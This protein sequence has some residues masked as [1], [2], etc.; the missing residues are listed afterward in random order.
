MNKVE[1][2]KFGEEEYE[3]SWIEGGD[4]A[5]ELVSQVSGYV[6]NNKGEILIVKNKNWTIPGGH[7]EEGEDY[8]ETLRREI[9]EESNVKI[10][11]ILY[12]GQVKL[13][14]LENKEIKYQLRYT[15]EV[16][17]IGDFKQNEFEVSE[18]LFIKPEDLTSYI[19]WANGVVFGLE[20]NA[21]TDRFS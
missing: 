9:I 19:P 10:T 16:E 21:A 3:F 8:I 20:V 6:F 11:N 4:P 13:V 5:V 17:M 2:V 7:P 12:L 18:R 14:N 15:A 1:I